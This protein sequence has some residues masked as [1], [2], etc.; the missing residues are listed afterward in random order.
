MRST[1]ILC[2][3]PPQMYNSCAFQS[4]YTIKRDP[5]GH[6][7][8]NIFVDYYDCIHGALV[9][10]YI[11]IDGIKTDLNVR[12]LKNLYSN[13]IYTSSKMSNLLDLARKW[14]NTRASIHFCFVMVIFKRERTN[15]KQA[16]KR[17]KN[18]FKVRIIFIVV[19]LSNHIFILFHIPS[20]INQIVF[21]ISSFHTITLNPPSSLLLSLV[22]TTCGPM[23]SG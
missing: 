13:S 12:D 17:V 14:I 11:L 5:V 18:E 23:I 1:R 10:Y 15:P 20:S 21:T 4:Q 3:F 7:D 8:V 6:V 16:V 22:I 2:W 9:I 19:H